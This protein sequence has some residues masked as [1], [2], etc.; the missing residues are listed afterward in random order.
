MPLNIDWQQILLHLF[1]FAILFTILYVLLYK[2]V[3]KFMDQRSDYYKELDEKAHQSVEDG[4]A[5]QNLYQQRL[6]K[7]NEEIDALRDQA[8]K[9]ASKLSE[10][11]IA[12][13][14][15]EASH[16]IAEAKTAAN[17]ERERIL[18]DAGDEISQ[19]V[20]DATAKIVFPDADSAYEDF[21]STVEGSEQNER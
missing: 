15:E 1:N 20:T 8:S 19:M 13:A 9:E 6:E 7:A 21:L 5:A 17:R 3:K 18:A 11:I 12:E 2:P 14:K 16:I 10:S 4:A